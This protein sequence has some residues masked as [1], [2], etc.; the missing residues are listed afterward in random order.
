MSV[1]LIQIIDQVGREKGIDPSILINAIEAGVLSACKKKYPDETLETIFNKETGE[2]GLFSCK[3]VLEAIEDPKKEITLEEAK[4]IDLNAKIDDTIKIPHGGQPFGRVAAQIAKQV[5]I[6]KV[7]EAEIDIVLQEFKEKK[8][9]LINGIVLRKERGDIVVDLGRAEGILP[10]KEQVPKESFKSGERVRA[11]LLDVKRNRKGA[12]VILSRTHSGLL[13]KLFQMEVPEVAEGIVEV[14]GAVREPNGRSKVA[15]YSKE[16][17]IDAVGSCVGMRGVRVQAIVSELRGEKID[18]VQWSEDPTVFVKKALSPAK[19]TKVIANEKE[20]HLIVVVPN[21]QLSLAIGKRGQ[22]VRLASRLL[23]WSIDIKS[24]TE[25]DNDFEAKE[26]LSKTKDSEFIKMLSRDH[27]L[28]I[29]IINLLIEHDL[30]EPDKIEEAGAESLT[31]I[32]GIGLKTAEKIIELCSNMKSAA[33]TLLKADIEHLE[34][35]DVD[36]YSID[37]LK[38]IGEKTL[39]ILNSSGYQTVAELSVAEIDELVSFEGIGHKKAEVILKAAREF[40]E[41][42]E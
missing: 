5:I 13:I 19:T 29:D 4:K 39:D 25:Y 27:S 23:K 12:Q 40:M 41:S 37:V 10:A 42:H 6:Q 34:T 30:I 31:K 15:V 36:D 21:D 8:D 18:I 35:A 1:K 20:K 24:E 17:S 7:R 33:K 38:G 2:V 9:E 16:K 28:D 22:N 14:K 26:V 11:Y 3:K 32:S